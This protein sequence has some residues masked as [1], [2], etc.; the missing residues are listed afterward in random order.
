MEKD[1][2]KENAMNIY[3]FENCIPYSTKLL[4][5]IFY[6]SYNLIIVNVIKYFFFFHKSLSIISK[7]NSISSTLVAPPPPI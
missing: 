4:K 7:R 2:T 3:R 5:Q 6:L 1:E